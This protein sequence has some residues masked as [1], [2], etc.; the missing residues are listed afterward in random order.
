MPLTESKPSYDW[1]VVSFKTST[2]IRANSLK[3][4]EVL[5]EATK[6]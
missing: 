1:N 4:D 5:G 3:T 6:G 2:F